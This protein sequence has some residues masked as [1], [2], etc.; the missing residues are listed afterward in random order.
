LRQAVEFYSRG[1]NVAPLTELDGTPIEPLGV[2]ALTPDEIGA[3]IAFL[4]AL[5][6][7]FPISHLAVCGGTLIEV[8]RGQ[9]R[10]QLRK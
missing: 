7:E 8:C 10:E 4:E 3:L 9:V 1:G 2:P 5:T 6:D